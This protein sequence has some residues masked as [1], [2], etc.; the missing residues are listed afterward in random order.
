[1]ANSNNNVVQYCPAVGILSNRR[2]CTYVSIIGSIIGFRCVPLLLLSIHLLLIL[3]CG[4]V[5]ENPGPTLNVKSLTACHINVRGLNEC[6]IRALKTTVCNV[7]DIITVSETFLSEN[8]TVDL[9]LPGYHSVTRRDRLTF[10]G[11]VAVY[12]KDNLVY[13][14]KPEF[15]CINLENLWI[16]VSSYDGKLLICTVYRPPNSD[17]FWEQFERNIEMVKDT[18]RNPKL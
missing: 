18:C 1:M 17:N 3:L 10:G 14:R 16:E 11:G 12:V 6:K 2:I 8:S 5:E 9:N 7:Y 13:R 4:D 15:E